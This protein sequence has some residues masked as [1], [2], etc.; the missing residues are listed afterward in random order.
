MNGKKY[1]G[2][3][4]PPKQKGQKRERVALRYCSQCEVQVPHS[5]NKLAEKGRF[6]WQWAFEE[7]KTKEAFWVSDL[8]ERLTS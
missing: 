8:P 6:A 3:A 5:E 2:Q 1:V 7:M 4:P